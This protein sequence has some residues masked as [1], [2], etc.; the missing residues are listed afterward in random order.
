[1]ARISIA[2]NATA[3]RVPLT[4]AQAATGFDRVLVVGLRV[5][6][7]AQAAQTEFETLLRHHAYSRTGL[8]L[9]PQGTPTNNTDATSSGFGRQDDADQSFDD[10]KAPLFTP[11]AD[12]LDKKDGQWLAEY[13]GVD[14]PCSRT[15]TMPT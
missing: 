13:L 7:D 1:M 8:S 3:F 9:V 11:A 10:R 4:A 14:P 5:N 2:P 15:S 12:W 6:A